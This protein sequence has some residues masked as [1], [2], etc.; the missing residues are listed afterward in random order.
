MCK[1]G[2]ADFSSGVLEPNAKHQR[3]GR[4]ARVRLDAL[5]GQLIVFS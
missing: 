4:H 3:R 1:E 5:V 2:A